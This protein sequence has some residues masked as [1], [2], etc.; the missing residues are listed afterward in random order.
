VTD[1]PYEQIAAG[2]RA[3]AASRRPTAEEI[4]VERVSPN[5]RGMKATTSLPSSAP[6][7]VHNTVKSK[8]LPKRVKGAAWFVAC[9]KMSDAEVALAKRE[10]I[11]YLVRAPWVKGRHFDSSK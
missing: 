1:Y 11:L 6:V 9:P 5:G 3:M 7:R 10:V 2:F 4:K 8:V